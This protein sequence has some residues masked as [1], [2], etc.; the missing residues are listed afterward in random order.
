MGKLTDNDRRFGPITYGPTGPTWRPLALTIA[1]RDDD[2]TRRCHLSGSAFGWTFRVWLPELVK[3]YVIRHKATSWD[4]A[5]IARIGRDWYEEIHPRE[6]GFR[7]SDGFLQVFLGPQTMDSL[8]TKDWC[9]HLPWTQWRFHATRYYGARG[10]LL[11]EWRDRKRAGGAMSVYDEQRA[12]RETMA[13]PAFLLRDFDGTEV[14]A[15]TYMEESDYK[16]GTG[17]FKWLSVFRPH[18]IRRSLDIQFDKEVGREKGSWKGGVRGHGIAMLPGE[19]HADAMRRYCGE[20]N[21]TF[22]EA[23]P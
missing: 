8:T 20:H 14:T 1:S 5:T 15:V 23:A 9:T 17:W 13:R 21:L 16:F 12:F 6:F 7:L 19:L 22:V 10:E 11:K 4:A 2:Y 3:P 18:R